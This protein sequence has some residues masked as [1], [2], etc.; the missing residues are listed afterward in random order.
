VA[1]RPAPSPAVAARAAALLGWTPTSW[2]KVVGGYTPAA[3]FIAAR[4]AER[5]FVKIA[6]TPLTADFLRR[7]GFVYERL[8]GSFMPRFVGWQDDEISPILIIEDLSEARWPPPWDSASVEA[9]LGRIDMLHASSAPLRSLSDVHGHTKGGW[10]SVAQDPAPFLSL[11][12]A[13]RE[14]LLRALPPLLEAE[15]ACPR[16]G[17]S[18]CHF[19][20]R[21]DNICLMRGEVRFVDWPAACL[22]NPQ[23][24]LGGWLPSLCFEGGPRPDDLLP[25]APQVAAWVSGYFAGRAGLPVIPDAPFVRRVQREQ[26]TT[27]L[28]WVARALKLGEL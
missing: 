12:L 20:L 4:G 13:S 15:S 19:D 8:A 18:V 1:V 6:T 14:W 2:R 25:D 3:R 11:G 22:G 24:D 26:L 23:L 17:S 21:S 16:D 5:A 28:P 7:E 9:V 27:A 10:A